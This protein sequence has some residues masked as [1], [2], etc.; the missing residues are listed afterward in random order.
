VRLPLRWVVL[1]TLASQIA[2]QTGDY[3]GWPA[4][5]SAGLAILGTLNSLVE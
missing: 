2:I 5:I 3:A 1:L 4:G